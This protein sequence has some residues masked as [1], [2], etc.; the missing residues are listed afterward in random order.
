MKLQ[1]GF[2]SRVCLLVILLTGV[3]VQDSSLSPKVPVQEPGVGLDLFTL[4]IS[5][6]RSLG[7]F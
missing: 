2:F 1:E 6:K 5:M 7:L 4:D 3:P